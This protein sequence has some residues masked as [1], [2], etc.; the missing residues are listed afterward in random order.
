LQKEKELIQGE[1]RKK[2]DDYKEKNKSKLERVGDFVRSTYVAAL[3]GHPKTL[4]KVGALAILRPVSEAT[5]KLTFGKVFDTVFPGISEAAKRGGES[6]SIRS[7]T[8]RL[9]GLFSADGQGKD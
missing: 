9:R 6:S 4:A 8:K 5:S 3:I 2:Q 1:Y 7:M